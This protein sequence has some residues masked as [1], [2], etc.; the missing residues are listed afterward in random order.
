MTD[1]TQQDLEERLMTWEEWQNEMLDENE[2]QNEQ[3]GED[4]DAIN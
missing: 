1:M 4:E 3:E 2:Q